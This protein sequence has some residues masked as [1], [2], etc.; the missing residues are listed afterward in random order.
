MILLVYSAQES[1]ILA[2]FYYS[3]QKYTER[4]RWSHAVWALDSFLCTS[5]YPVKKSD[6]RK[7]RVRQVA[8]QTSH[9][10]LCTL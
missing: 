2:P 6:R 7:F 1:K 4:Q 5:S 8:L 3:K 10:Y 9:F